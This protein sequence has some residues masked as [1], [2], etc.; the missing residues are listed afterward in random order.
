MAKINLQE[1]LGLFSD[2]W[3]PRII[4]EVNDHHVKLVKFQ[5]EF[6]W[7]SHETEDELFLVIHGSFQMQYS[8]HQEILHEGELVVVPHGT[9]HRPVA[10]EEVHCLLFEPKT[11][12]NTG[13]QKTEKTH[14]QLEKI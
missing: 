14:T 4:E 12:L 2:Y 1:K 9:L 11:T 8:E 13:D 7:H 6:D 5:G 10:Q 3:N